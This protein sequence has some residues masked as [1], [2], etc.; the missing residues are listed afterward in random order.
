MLEIAEKQKKP[1]PGFWLLTGWEDIT[2]IGNN[3]II[4]IPVKQLVSISG[5]FIF[6][7]QSCI[8]N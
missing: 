3:L 8:N 7:L 6:E 1:A 4:T 2:G 5:T